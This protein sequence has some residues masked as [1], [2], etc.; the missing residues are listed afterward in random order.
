MGHNRMVGLEIFSRVTAEKRQELLQSVEVLLGLQGR[1]SACISQA[2]FE[3]VRAPNH[4]LWVEHWT[5]NAALEAHLQA[6][7]FR[8]LLGAIE[9]LGVLEDLRIVELTVPPEGSS[10]QRP[11]R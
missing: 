9:V 6:E 5:T 1:P 10:R 7:R 3:D 4:F 11:V 2:L 8:T